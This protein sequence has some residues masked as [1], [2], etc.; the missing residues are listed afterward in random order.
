MLKT[1]RELTGV[2]RGKGWKEFDLDGQRRVH[3]PDNFRRPDADDRLRTAVTEMILDLVKERLGSEWE[4][5][6]TDYGLILMG[7]DFEQIQDT[8]ERY[9]HMLWRFQG[10]KFIDK[11]TKVQ[12][13]SR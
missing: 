11:A 1:Q 4:E 12:A 10:V 2:V 9:E 6:I 8:I 13:P 5:L 7:S 3:V